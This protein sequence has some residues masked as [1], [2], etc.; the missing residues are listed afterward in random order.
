M[1]DFYRPAEDTILLQRHVVRLVEGSVLD[2]G[3]GSGVLAVEAALKPEV[4]DILAIDIN[5][6]AIKEAKRRAAEYNI[7][8]KVSFRVSDLF[9]GV[10]RRFDWIVFNPPYLPDEGAKDPSWEGGVGGADIIERFL[11]GA[12]NHLKKGGSILIVYSSLTNLD[13]SEHPDYDWEILEVM[14]LFFE[15]LYCARLRPVSPA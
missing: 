1:E 8:N 15:K 3:T 4:T 10:T 11:R 13:P 12:P 5:P 14:S 9:E 6:S 7:S 2:M